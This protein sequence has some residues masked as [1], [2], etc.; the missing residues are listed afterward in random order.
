MESNDKGKIYVETS[1]NMSKNSNYLKGVIYETEN[2]KNIKIYK[3][4]SKVLYIWFAKSL[5][6]FGWDNSNT[7]TPQ[8]IYVKY[9]F[10]G[11]Y[12][13]KQLGDLDVPQAVESLITALNDSNTI[14]V[15]N[16]ALKVWSSLESLRVIIVKEN[17]MMTLIKSLKHRDFK[18]RELIAKIIGELHKKGILFSLDKTHILSLVNVEAFH[19]DFS[20]RAKIERRS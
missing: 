10:P 7:T 12:W 15:Q 13:Q 8:D 5:T 19:E 14:V 11:T 16:A 2:E 6:K 20:Q 9:I 18:V 17:V 4:E 1:F 3:S